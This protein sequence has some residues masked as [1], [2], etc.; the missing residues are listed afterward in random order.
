MSATELGIWLA[1]IDTFVFDLDGVV[2]NGKNLIDGAQA[3]LE[4]LRKLGKTLKFVTNNA[5]RSRT[6]VKAKFEAKGL[7]GIEEEDIV[8]SASAT[9]NYL[10]RAGIATDGSETVYVHGAT[11]LCEELR[12][13][14][15]TVMGGDADSGK[16]ASDIDFDIGTLPTN[17]TAVVVS[18]DPNIGFYSIS[19]AAAFVRYRADT[20]RQFVA[21]NRDLASPVTDSGMLVP[22][23]G[24][25]V[26][27]ILFRS[28]R[29][30]SFLSPAHT[31]T[32]SPGGGWLP[33]GALR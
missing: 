32:R 26:I 18:F 12:A 33:P 17:V 2:W 15:F 16:N 22:G 5:T 31:L 10:V 23:G 27:S 14:G 20:V 4:L 13:V 9:A 21:T 3:T 25:Q 6:A 24:C 1:Q 29:S 11:G 8:T 30:I 7:S 28:I 19:K